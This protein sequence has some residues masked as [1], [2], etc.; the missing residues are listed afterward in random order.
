MQL[1]SQIFSLAASSV[2]F[3]WLQSTSVRA[4]TDQRFRRSSKRALVD[5]FSTFE[6]IPRWSFQL[7]TSNFFSDQQ[8]RRSRRQALMDI[9][10]RQSLT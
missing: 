5:G 3:L 8:L 4:R 10:L 9:D 6:K 2:D 7:I 1:F